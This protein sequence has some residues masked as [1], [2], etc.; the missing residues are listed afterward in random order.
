MLSIEGG[1]HHVPYSL[2]NREPQTAEP[3]H[4]ISF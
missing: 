4:G 3:T 2:H 1:D